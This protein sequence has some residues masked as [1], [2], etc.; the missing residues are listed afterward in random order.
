MEGLINKKETITSIEVAKI[1][2]KNHAHL[3][4]DIRKMEESWVKVA[5]SKFGLG[6]YKDK[7]KQERPMYILSKTECLYIATKFNDEARAKLVLR[8]EELEREAEKNMTSAEKYMRDAMMFLEQEKKLNEHDQ[9]ISVLEAKEKT[10]PDY[11]SVVGYASL[12]KIQLNNS[13]AMRIGR[14]ASSICKKRDLLMD[15]TTDSRFGQVKLYPS[16]ILEEVF[17]S[18]LA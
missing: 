9:R 17:N 15:T 11:F 18:E 4:R 10:R 13:L 6:S 12:N 14:K 3:M 1:T 16:K 8:W 5:Q 2:E 7:N